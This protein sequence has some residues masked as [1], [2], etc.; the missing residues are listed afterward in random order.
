MHLLWMFPWSSDDGFA[1]VHH[2][3]IN[4]DLGTR[5]DIADLGTDHA[6]MFGFVANHTSSTSTWFRSWLARDPAYADHFLQPDP[7]LRDAAG[8]E[9]RRPGDGAAPGSGH[10]GEL[11]CVTN[12][13]DA[14]VT[15]SR[16]YGIDVLTGT[17]AAPLRLGRP[18]GF[19]WVRP[20]R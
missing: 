11:L 4:P 14:D 5:Q 9:A 17:A 3:A 8:G 18:Y 2:R 20:R 13:T 15:L 16:V 1:V 6:L 12:V 19:A 10:G 7:S